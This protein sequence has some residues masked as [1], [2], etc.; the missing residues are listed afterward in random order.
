MSLHTGEP[1]PPSEY[2]PHTTDKVVLPNHYAR[3]R[4]EPIRFI[5]E[6]NGPGFL[7]ENATKYLWRYDAKDGHQDLA[8]VARYVE[9]LRMYEA[10]FNNWSLPTPSDFQFLTES[11]DLLRSLGFKAPGHD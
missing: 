5:V 8:K 9:M 11:S 4:L 3:H 2:T 10:G 1:P 7:I 6:N